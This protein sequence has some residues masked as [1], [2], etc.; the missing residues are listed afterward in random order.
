MPLVLVLVVA[1]LCLPVPWP[2]PPF[3]EEWP[4]SERVAGAAAVA[5]AIP[6]GP[7]V[8]AAALALWVVVS[9]RRDPDRRVEIGRTYGRIRRTL[10][11][12]ALAATAAGAW[13]G[14]WG[15]VVW[16]GWE[17]LKISV[18]DGPT[19]VLAPGAELLVPLP[20]FLAVLLAW[21][22]VFRAE[23]ALFNSDQETYGKF[24]TLPGYVFFHAR[25]FVLIVLLPVGL[26]VAQHGVT[27]TFPHVS[28]NPGFQAA[29]FVGM[30]VFFTVL[31]RFLRPLLGW[32]TL[33]PGPVRTQLERSAARLGLRYTDLLVWPTRGAVANALIVG[34][35]PRARYVVFTDRL[36]DGM[37][38]DEIDAVLGH[39]IGHVRHG[40]IPFY[41]GFLLLSSA[42]A[43]AG[44]ALVMESAADFGWEFT[45]DAAGWLSIPPVLATGAYLFL[46]FGLLSRRCERQ[47]D[48]FGGR[49]GSCRNPRCDGHD[50][51]TRL[52]ENGLGLC[53][54][55]VRAMA[56]ALDKVAVL[57]GLESRDPGPGKPIRRIWGQVNAWQHGPIPERIEF[58]YRLAE[59]PSLGDRTDRSTFRFRVGLLATLLVALGGLG[60]AVGWGRLLT[61][62]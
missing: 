9:L 24:W 60:T 41:L 8:A 35:I 10:G 47:A 4:P 46:V 7:V 57:N 18:G 1:V 42:A 43:T 17:L 33:P 3:G 13:F 37:E 50:D 54:T 61:M 39:E 32:K 30:L 58:L 52:A 23:R 48:V 51:D 55:G 62:L 14:G 44:I 27:R 31:P 22:V 49:A 28:T 11:L 20:Y 19:R 2:P 38:R 25:Q 34:L 53:P 40:H 6:I 16:N 15:W 21:V 5:V 59:D 29:S 12:I 45:P 56:R 36:L 26:F